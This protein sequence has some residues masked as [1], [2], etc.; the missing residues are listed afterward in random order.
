MLFVLN[1]SFAQGS[2]Y[3]VQIGSEFPPFS[4]YDNGILTGV[5]IEMLNRIAFENGIRVNLSVGNKNQ[6]LDNLSKNRIDI[7]AG[8]LYDSTIISQASVSLPFAFVSYDLF[9]T[10]NNVVND[11]SQLK[12]DQIL[13][14][15]D[16]PI[17]FKLSKSYPY[18]KI[19]KVNTIS[20]ALMLL[21]NESYKY[22][23]LP[24]L[25]AVLTSEDLGYKNIIFNRLFLESIPLVF[26]VQK[27]NLELLSKINE[28]ILLLH[29][30]PE[31]NNIL[32]K[33][34]GV[35]NDGDLWYNGRYFV[36]VLIVLINVLLIFAIWLITF[37]QRINKRKKE[38]SRIL[39]IIP[40]YIYIKNREGKIVYANNAFSS[41][42]NLTGESIA[43]K[44]HSDIHMLHSEM[45]KIHEIENRFFADKSSLNQDINEETI[46]LPDGSRQ[47]LETTRVKLESESTRDYEI[48]AISID[49]TDRVTSHELLQKS[50]AKFKL[51]FDNAG[52]SIFL[53]RFDG[54]IIDF[55]DQALKSLGYSQEEMFKLSAWDIERNFTHFS[56]SQF[57]ESLKPNQTYEV[58]GYHRRK[59]GTG[60]R[61]NVRL[62]IINIENER[63]ILAI[64]ADVEEK[65]RWEDQKK[66]QSAALNA[67]AN[68]IV[69][70]D[71]EGYIVWVNQ[72][73][74]KL[75]G[76]SKEEAVTLHTR[77]LKSGRQSTAFYKELWE[78]V[79]S[80]KIWQGILINKRK[81]DSLYTEEATITPVM[82]ENGVITHFISIKNDITEKQLIENKIRDNE[83][84]YR[85]LFNKAPVGI[86][87]FD[88]NMILNDFND[89]FI[90]I[91]RSS[92]E[93]LLGLNLSTLK[94]QVFVPNIRNALIG[95]DGHYS[96]PYHTTT[97]DHDIYISIYTRPYYNE[98]N[99]ITGGIGIVEDITG[100]KEIELELKK[101]EQKYRSIFENLMDVYYMTDMNGVI[102][103]VSPSITAL[104]KI[105][106]AN[107]M[108]GVDLVNKYYANTS[109]RL[110]LLEKIEKHGFVKN[111]QL[112]LI[113]EDGEKIFIETN[114][115]YVYDEN[116]MPVAI[117]GM[118]RDITSR[119]KVEHELRLGEQKL[120]NIIENSSDGIA[121]VDQEGKI[122]EWNSAMENIT[123]YDKNSV[124]NKFIWDIQY[125]FAPDE[126]DK[127]GY[128]E[129]LREGVKAALQL[130]HSE[131]PGP[132]QEAKIKRADG[133]EIYTQTS[134]ATINTPQGNMIVSITRDVSGIKEVEEQMRLAKEQAEK[135]NKLKSEFL[136]QMSHEIRTPV[137][138]ILSFAGLMEEELYDK[139]EDD[140][141]DGF[142]IMRN[143][144]NRIIRTIDLI[145]NMSEIQTG[146]YDYVK[147]EI[148]LYSDILINITAEHKNML[149]L[150]GLELNII[151]PAM[152][153]TITGDEYTVNQIFTNLIDNA[154][155][156]TSR[157]VIEVSFE[158]GENFLTVNIKDTGIGISQEYLPY[159]FEPFTQEEQGYTRKFE[160]N[161]LGLALVKKYCDLNNAV[162]TV[163]SKKGEGSLFKVTFKD[164]S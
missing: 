34:S 164:Q 140:L 95:A 71:R 20:E 87:Q 144:G 70:V 22:A 18:L 40:H 78:T 57:I 36:M 81:D 150:K 19:K 90:G 64:C 32:R 21:H 61:V 62:A 115:H 39:E 33:W 2:A 143:A 83:Q 30:S 130:R 50:E 8:I 162:I 132:I 102:L 118:M 116:N 139:L 77:Q 11:K 126:T 122:I 63:L 110:E 27:N 37:R 6:L 80:G 44:F 23:I 74:C 96:G 142:K 100:F 29:N 76:Y 138:A 1:N 65:K 155:K 13:I 111:F 101:S 42:Y 41:I 68:G 103:N 73:F 51:L 47:I 46:T 137:N 105:K 16:D 117:E 93:K 156:Y 97:S 88:R 15:K 86:F 108:V 147:S 85:Y 107:E 17:Y 26:V 66:L 43:G 163:S 52:V 49:I 67:A 53:H 92:R 56:G 12:A 119:K 133:K 127:T 25:P 9:S 148:E 10:K 149:K 91:F 31:Y 158:K 157:G 121:L 98:N 141:N 28:G 128:L 14:V 124:I 161:G 72:A 151:K 136:A 7:A 160:G 69:I 58:D 24:K 55:N 79:L 112:E 38:I 89:H 84:R 113:R 48:L 82:D 109:K 154:I 114:S 120:R 35:Y 99:E 131:I 125:K 5:S 54:T 129:K 159:L 146:T 135:S 153:T 145:L 152:D 45:K 4:Y 123:A 75:T 60:F 106:D 134:V 3:R 104:L 94:D 59:D